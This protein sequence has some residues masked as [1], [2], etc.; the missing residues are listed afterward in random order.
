MAASGITLTGQT[1][2]QALID[3]GRLE[4]GQTILINGGS[5]AVGALAIQIAKA[6]GAKVYATASTKNEEFVRQQGADEASSVSFTSNLSLP[7]LY[8]SS[9]TTPR[10]LCMNTL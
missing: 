7:F 3:V 8:G 4:P 9:S 1:A 5:S 10:A 2:Y 6:K